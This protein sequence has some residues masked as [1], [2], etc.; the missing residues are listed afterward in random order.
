MEISWQLAGLTGEGMGLTRPV[1]VAGW[2]GPA[3]VDLERNGLRWREVDGDRIGKIIRVRR[4]LLDAF[5]RL[6]D[7]EPE[8]IRDYARRWG[9]LMICEHGIPAGHSWPRE[10]IV[11]ILNGPEKDMLCRPRGWPD[12]CWESV[13]A[14]YVLARQARAL[15]HVAA[16][17]HNGTP[18]RRGDWQMVVYRTWHGDGG[19]D[20]W[21]DKL[22]QPR[23]A[24]SARAFVEESMQRWL[25]WGA[26]QPVL[27]WSA[28]KDPTIEFE[29]VGLFGALAVQ[30]LAAVIRE[31]WAVCAGCNNQYAPERRPNAKRR[32]Y[33]PDC[34]TSGVSHRD[35]MRDFRR[36]SPCQQKEQ[37]R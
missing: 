24:A 16:A 25:A 31:G 33:C 12:A 23:H 26:V 1:T 17:L 2:R 36:R 14:W 20:P 11:D 9:V 22:N 7:T 30:L 6:A 34:R 32:N 5:V 27:A 15:L 8:A 21:L 10:P 35:A 28:K 19:G 18:A 4:G 29:G 13:G 3:A 37:G